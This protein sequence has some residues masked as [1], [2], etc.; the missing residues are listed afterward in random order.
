MHLVQ[1]LDTRITQHAYADFS[2]ASNVHICIVPPFVQVTIIRIWAVLSAGQR[3]WP[4]WNRAEKPGVG[5]PLNDMHVSSMH[6]HSLPSLRVIPVWPTFQSSK[7]PRRCWPDSKGQDT[8][9]GQCWHSVQEY[10]VHSNVDHFQVLSADFLSLGLKAPPAPLVCA[11]ATHQIWTNGYCAHCRLR[12]YA[13]WLHTCT[14][15]VMCIKPSSS[16][17]RCEHSFPLLVSKVL[18]SW[19]SSILDRP[20]VQD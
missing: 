17:L 10:P 14:F 13:R 12:A 8:L 4:W 9:C 1:V 16:C 18:T 19:W 15:K 11:P 2:C 5:Q 3:R 20:S 7:P 6:F